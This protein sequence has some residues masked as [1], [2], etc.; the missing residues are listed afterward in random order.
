[1]NLSNI[2]L[3]SATLDDLETLLSFEQG[4]IAAER[5]FDPTLKQEGINYYNLESM[6]QAEDVELVVA[7]IE[8][9]IVGCGYIRIEQAKPYHKF[10]EYA[11]MGF[12]YVKPEY[13][14]KGVS[15]LLMDEMLVWARSKNIIEVRLDVF[16]DN[17]SAVRAYEKAGY[18]K[19]LV[20]MRL[21]LSDE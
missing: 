16:N 9:E 13:R 11:Y 5:P 12:M 1:M 3:R 2:K 18:K 20:K 14:G 21:D 8:D 15:Q 4:V 10:A 7:T 19:H 17:S 6:I